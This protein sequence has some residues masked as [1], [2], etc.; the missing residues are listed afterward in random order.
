[1]KYFL[2]A[3]GFII[4]MA[5]IIFGVAIVMSWLEDKINA[6]ILDPMKPK[7]IADDLREVADRVDTLYDWACTDADYAEKNG[8]DDAEA[9]QKCAV[10]EE[11]VFRLRESAKEVAN[12]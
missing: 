8:I 3:I 4:C 7:N 12:L 2:E 1:M 5:V 9:E 10:L 6:A 11:I